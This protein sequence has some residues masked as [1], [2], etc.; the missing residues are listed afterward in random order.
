M[1]L[2]LQRRD[3]V[4]RLGEQVQGEKPA[5]ERQLRGL[6]DGAGGERHLMPAAAALGVLAPLA[7]EAAVQVAP[8]LRTYESARPACL[9]K[10][11]PALFLGAVLRHELRHRKPGLKL[12]TVHRHRRSPRLRAPRRLSRSICITLAHHVS[13][14]EE[15]R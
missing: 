11:R 10:R 8:A 4:L 2:Q 12:D 6:E 15:C 3:V 1:A 9:V 7:L 14:A 13:L 5:R